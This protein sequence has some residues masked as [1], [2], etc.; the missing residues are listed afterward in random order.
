[1]QEGLARNPLPQTKRKGRGRPAKGKVRCLLERLRDYRKQYLA[2]LF[3]LSLPFTNSEAERDLRMSKVKAKVS[4]CFRTV[5]GAEV[6]CR[7]RSYIVTCQ[8][9]GMALLECLRSLFDGNLILPSL[10]SA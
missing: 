2:F 5:T 3:D 10:N 9:Q 4:G 7:L 1:M 8:K 6:F